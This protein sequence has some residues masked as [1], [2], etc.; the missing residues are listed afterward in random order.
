[1]P[2]VL[3]DTNATAKRLGIKVPTL[4]KTRLR[5]DGPP[6]IRIGGKVL[7]DEKDVEA[8]IA[9][10]PRLNSTADAQARS[11]RPGAGRPPKTAA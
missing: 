7:Y 6:Y 1:M 10:R 3:L 4:A 2:T 9:E 5:G 8:F 11:R